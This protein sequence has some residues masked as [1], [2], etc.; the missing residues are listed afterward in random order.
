MNGVTR[1][2]PL[3]SALL[4]LSRPIVTV[5]PATETVSKTVCAAELP[6]DGTGADTDDAAVATAEPATTSA[7]PAAATRRADKTDTTR[8]LDRSNPPGHRHRGNQPT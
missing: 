3:V 5:C 7:M 2:F 8:P 4:T 1:T 6:L